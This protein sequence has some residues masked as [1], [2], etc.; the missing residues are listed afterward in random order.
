VWKQ[1]YLIFGYY[2]VKFF[3]LGKKLLK[4][5]R[6]LR[7][8]PPDTSSF[9][10]AGLFFTPDLYSNFAKFVKLDYLPR[11]LGTVLLAALTGLVAQFAFDYYLMDIL[12]SDQTVRSYE[13]KTL[14]EINPNTDNLSSFYL[15]HARTVARSVSG[16]GEIIDGLSALNKLYPAESEKYRSALDKMHLE[17]WLLFQLYSLMWLVARGDVAGRTAVLSALIAIYSTFLY[18]RKRAAKLN[19]R[20]NP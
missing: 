4:S 15:C 17:Q 8:E 3:N 20:Q 16:L 18:S 6:I 1:S 5:V 13:N 9:G 10:L 19:Q 12:C 2:S 11:A 7:E 14:A